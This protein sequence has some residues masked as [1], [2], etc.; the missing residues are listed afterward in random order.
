MTSPANPPIRLHPKNPKIFEFRGRPL[1]LV[2]ATEHYGAVMNRPFRFERYVAEAADKSLTLTRLFLLFR[3][4]QSTHNPYSTCKP[5]S[6]DYVTPFQRTGPGQAADGLPKYDLTRWNPEFFDRLHRFMALT[7]ERG[8]VVEAVLLS[9]TYS[10]QVWA[11]N[12]L[13]SV[14]NVNEVETIPWTDYMTRRHAKLF[15]WQCAHARKMVEE[16]NRYDNVFFEICNEPGGAIAIPGAPTVD[17]V[18]D[19]LEAFAR[20]IRETEGKL[21]HQHLIAGQEAFSYSHRLPNSGHVQQLSEKSFRDF[22]VDVVNMHPL[23]NMTYRGK[24]YDL[25]NFMSGE[26]HLRELRRYCLDVYRE[27]KPL[28]LDE[29]NAASRFRDENGWTIHRKRAWTTLFCGAHYDMIDFSIAPYLETGTPDS[30]KLLR[31]WMQR[32]SEYMRSVDLIRARPLESFLTAQPENTVGSVLAVEGEEYHIYLAD[33]RES[34]DPGAGGPV[35]GEIGFHLPEGGYRLTCTSPATG[36]SSPP[37][38]LCG[39]VNVTLPL[40]PFTHDL[41]VRIYKTR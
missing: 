6:T 36:E 16:L 35:Q 9:N 18:N 24:V 21:P 19:W 31:T 4:F 1:V 25:G 7:S 33:G 39:G 27:R 28:N 20:L 29:D 8:I 32:L 38:E 14:N 26:L 12:P 15:A 41:V 11:V 37:G 2:T 17:E 5:E 13:N 34:S 3:E 10:D 22:P 30:Q 40:R 23:P